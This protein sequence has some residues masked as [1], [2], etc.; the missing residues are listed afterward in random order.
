M[1]GAK[2]A[3]NEA[4]EL[5]RTLEGECEAGSVP[6]A[7]FEDFGSLPGA[8]HVARSELGPPRASG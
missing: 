4:V 3:E 1:G 6:L 7:W 5:L 2:M 8:V